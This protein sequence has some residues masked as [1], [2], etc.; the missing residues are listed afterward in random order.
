M[1]KVKVLNQ[2]KLATSLA[3]TLWTGNILAQSA[4]NVPAGS[5][6]QSVEPQQTATTA[7]TMSTSTVDQAKQIQY[8]P[9]LDG[10]GL[11]PMNSVRTLHLLVGGTITSGFD[12]NPDNLSNGASAV[13]YSFSPYVG[14]QASTSRTQYLL[15]YHPTISRYTSYAGGS[16]QEGS[17]RILGS[18]S[19]RWNWTF[20][21]TGSHG[22]DSIR[23]LAPQQSVAIGNVPASGPNS[24]SYLPNAGNV[25][26]LDGAFELRYEVSPKD[27]A[28]IQIADTF[29]SYPA[30]HESGSVATT[31]TNYSHTLRPSLSVLGYQQT[32]QYFG[33]LR[34]TTFGGGAGFRWQPRESTQFSF[35]G[36]PQF[37]SPS[38]KSQQGYTYS[39]AFSTRLPG[40]SQFY[41]VA[42]REPTASYLGPGL[43][44][45]DVSGGFERQFHSA[46]LVTFDVGFVY[47]STLATASSYHGTFFDLSYVR[48][49]RREVSLRCSYRSY[50]GSLGTTD[51]NR[52][53]VILSL[54]FTPNARTLFQ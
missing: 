46:N 49:L 50:S 38:C 17:A 4:T 6:A 30:L 36:G 26:D 24:A 8:V 48:A 1:K 40:R 35:K 29:N 12:S 25:T 43:W 32:S 31:N 51:F 3:M 21:M 28:G 10:E 34:C 33:E 18:I 27:T 53:M 41:L 2:I 37:N 16:M 22:Q 7:D 9:A 39:A 13:L 23:L 14:V 47:S 5:D 20:G 11:I 54:T 44:Q 15:Q 52:N 19:Q 45:D 42:D